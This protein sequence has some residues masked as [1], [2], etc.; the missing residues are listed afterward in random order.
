VF[1]VYIFYNASLDS[2]HN[3]RSYMMATKRCSYILHVYGE[4]ISKLIN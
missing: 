2:L 3:A 1:I 4:Q